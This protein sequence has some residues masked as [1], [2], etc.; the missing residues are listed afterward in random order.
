MRKTIPARDKQLTGMCACGFQGIIVSYGGHRTAE[1]YWTCLNLCLAD[2]TLKCLCWSL[3]Q[4]QEF[5]FWT[6]FAIHKLY[7][8]SFPT[9]SMKQWLLK[10]TLDCSRIK[11]T[12]NFL[13]NKCLVRHD[14]GRLDQCGWSVSKSYFRYAN[15][16][17]NTSKSTFIK[18]KYNVKVYVVNWS[19]S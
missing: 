4:L 8:L 1:T 9:Q 6:W 17:N 13:F 3:Y 10:T 12:A 14:C 7:F 2:M 16:L 18:Q 11:F 5:A 19:H 15:T